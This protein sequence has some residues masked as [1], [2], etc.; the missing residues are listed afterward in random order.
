M[1]ERTFV[2]NASF[3][4]IEEVVESHF[5]LTATVR[6]RVQRFLI[7]RSD[8]QLVNLGMDPIVKTS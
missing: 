5:H 2:R 4:V 1:Y 8:L 6:E 7:G 3:L